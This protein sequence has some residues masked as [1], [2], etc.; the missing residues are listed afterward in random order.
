MKT[1]KQQQ[2]ELL[3]RVDTY[4]LNDVIE[5]AF[6]SAIQ[7]RERIDKGEATLSQYEAMENTKRI[8]REMLNN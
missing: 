3:L 2:Q 6:L 1:L 7:Y 4:L 8:I 5:T